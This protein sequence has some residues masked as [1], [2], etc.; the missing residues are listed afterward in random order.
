VAS[1]RPANSNR[2]DNGHEPTQLTPP[3]R[4]LM[5]P[6][7]L[8]DGQNAWRTVVLGDLADH[9]PSR[10]GRARLSAYFWYTRVFL[11]R[12]TPCDTL[13]TVMVSPQNN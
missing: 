3:G 10:N 1:T 7:A 12:V 6:N 11:M 2:T 9:L 8:C 5:K 4:A 13:P